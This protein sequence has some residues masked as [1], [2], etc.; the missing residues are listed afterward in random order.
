VSDYKAEAGA[1]A[2]KRRA[3]K[4]EQTNADRAAG[5]HGAK[6]EAR[7]NI[8]NQRQQ[9]E[10]DVIG[11]VA[12]RAGWSDSDLKFQEADYEHLSEK[13]RGKVRDRHHALLLKRAKDVIQQSR[14]KLVNDAAARDDAGVGELPLNSD[15]PDDVSAQDLDPVKA[16]GSGL[17]FQADYKG[18]A[19]AKGLT[20][21]AVAAEADDIKSAGLTPEQRAAAMSKPA[22]A[23]AAIKKELEGIK[24]P[25]A[26]NADASLLSAQ[27]A[28]ELV[29]EGKKLQQIERASRDANADVDKAKSEPKAF[30]L[31]TDDDV[32]ASVQ[33]DLQND[34]RT[35][36]TRAFLSEVGKIAGAK[37]D[38]TLG[39]HI[40]VGA[41]N[42]I[43]AL[44]LAV[45]GDALVDRSVLDVLGVA[46]AAQVLARRFHADL[47]PNEIQDVADGIQ[48]WHVNHY[49]KTSTEALKKAR[50]L[51]DAAEAITL[52]DDAVK[53]ADL[54]VAQELNQR[55]RAAVGD[56]QR[57]LGQAL[58]EMEANAALV[59]AMKAPGKGDFQVSL[60]KV[61]PDQA[62]QQVRAIGLMPG[63][64]KLERADGDMFLTVTPGGMGRLASPVNREDVAQVRRNVAI[65]RGDQDE[66]GWLPMGVANRPDLVMDVKAGVAERLAKPFEPGDDLQASLRTYIGARAADGDPPGD[67]LSDIQSADFFQKVGSSRTEDYRMALD[68]VAPLKGADG[69]QQRADALS[70]TFDGYAD[71]H[72]AALGGDRSTLN[73]QKVAVDQHSV[74]A[75]HRALAET[76]EGTA[77][78]KQIGELSGKDQSALRE[79]FYQHIAHESPRPCRSRD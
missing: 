40:G 17:G 24:E 26:P 68:A 69:K 63:D 8:K 46:G 74:D 1:S 67:I 44:A 12:K 16:L 79:H 55:R 49:M 42:S 45:G 18:R 78:Y 53:G 77:A 34:L 35:L 25:A 20:K 52:S 61:A 4:K 72:V 56:A 71:A 21:E 9:A 41:Y 58:G 64:Y 48:D 54:A 10:R 60:G 36:Q 6:Q 28:L 14:D 51:T 66:D 47:Q 43:N 39:G 27:D 13:A 31:E 29:K 2:A 7:A 19:E 62:I 76:P 38:E 37:T 73:S 75:L 5:I 33:E 3:E 70:E 15:S 65:M 11:A 32:D 50:D 57:I 59:V 22:T 23:A 30:V